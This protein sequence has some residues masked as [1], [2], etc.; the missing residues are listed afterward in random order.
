MY[1]I[2]L[3]PWRELDHLRT[4]LDKMFDQVPQSRNCAVKTQQNRPTRTP[5]IELQNTEEALILRVEVP[6]MEAKD[7][8]IQVSR[9]AVQIIGTYTQPATAVCT[10][11]RYG[12]IRRVIELPLPVEQDQVKA[13]LKN[14]I[15]TLS[16]PKVSAVR[17]SVV[18]INL[19]EVAQTQTEGKTENHTTP[20]EN[21]ATDS[22]IAGDLWENTS[23]G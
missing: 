9:Q 17:P 20:A 12:E 2:Y 19:A 15:L 10:E 1:P 21:S 14:G 13:D 11:F 6:G 7:L 8:D 4:Q 22:E 18:K 16:L 5:A 3:Q 23:A